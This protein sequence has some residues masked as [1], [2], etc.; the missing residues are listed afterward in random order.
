MSG[1]SEIGALSSRQDSAAESAIAKHSSLG[2]AASELHQVEAEV[3]EL[4]QGM[5]SQVHFSL[6]LSGAL[7]QHALVYIPVRHPLMLQ[8]LM[9]L[10]RSVEHILR[11]RGFHA[12]VVGHAEKRA[13]FSVI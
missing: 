6:T 5:C 13:C 4:L 8:V 12:G 3:E 11:F 1:G 9:L 2:A 7:T 10:V